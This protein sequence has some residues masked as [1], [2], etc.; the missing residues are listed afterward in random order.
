MN[1]TIVNW[2]DVG[3]QITIFILLVALISFSLSIW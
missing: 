3:Y 2:F 1:E